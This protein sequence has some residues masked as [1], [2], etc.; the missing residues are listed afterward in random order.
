MTVSSSNRKAGPFLGNGVTTAFPFAFKVFKKED[1][2]VTFT[3]TNGADAPLV[4]DSDYSVALNSNQD[5]NPGGTITCPTVASALPPLATG[6]R[7]TLTG[8]LAYNQPTDIPNNSPFFAQTV[9]DAL[10]RAEIQIQQLKEITD[11]S[12][13]I[14]VSDAPL[15]PLPTAAVRSNTVVGFDALGNVITLPLPASIGAGDMRVDTFTAGVD[16]TAGVTTVLNLSR[17]PGN[18][19]NLEIFFDPLFQGPDQWNL[20]GSTVTFTGPIPVGVAK[21]FAR[22]GTTLSTQIPPNGSVGDAQLAWGS[23]LYRGVDTLAQMRT[24]N[25]ALYPCVFASGA[26]AAGD[27]GGG[28]YRVIAATQGAYVD[29]GG[30][31]IVG[32][33]GYVLQLVSKAAP[34]INQFGSNPTVGDNTAALNHALS[35]DPSNN[36]VRIPPGIVPFS[37]TL[38]VTTPGHYAGEG[39]YSALKPG[40]G[41]SGGSNNLQFKPNAALGVYLPV[42]EKFTLGDPNTGTRNGLNGIYI[43]TNTISSFVPKFTLRDASILAGV[44]GAAV[45][46]INT[47]ASNVNGGL[48][49]ANFD[50][51]ILQ[52][53]I[54]LNSTGDSNCI[55]KC[56]ISGPNT[57]IYAS[58]VSGASLLSIV[59]NNITNTN[60][61]IQI[62]AGARF[63]ILRNN[64][65]QQV[66][67]ANGAVHM[68][69]ISGANGTMV[70][71]E[72]RGNHFGLF[73]GVLNAANLRLAN[74]Q[75]TLVSEN[76]F[77]NANASPVAIIVDATC[78]NTRIGP[79]SYGTGLTTK[80]ID[81]G[82]GTM[83]V[84]KNATLA[85]AWLNY[86][87]NIAQFY[88]D[89]LGKVT[90][91][92]AVTG[93]SGTIC[94]LPVGFRPAQLSYFSVYSSNGG[95]QV[96][97]S[98]FVDTL[99]NV[100]YQAG[101]NVLFSLD[102][103]SFLAAGLADTPSDL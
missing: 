30:S 37:T 11:R 26:L 74:A 3:N 78:V 7:L 89:I 22:I 76:T 55:H 29:N 77:L 62:D 17:P 92:G 95:A 56:L 36:A 28:A 10:D 88:K 18:P 73:S 50:N 15:T 52:G 53:G 82:I 5:T 40:A 72:I 71:G 19:A 13:K 33:D 85:G 4:L 21:V 79:N 80:V 83:G 27:G 46:A 49:S 59:D 39:F 44:A 102:G 31:I 57:G 48:Y 98:V 47:P 45:L 90:L 86:S 34:T 51:N 66:P 64:L 93:G 25:H 75:G 20:S 69:N 103:V 12:I 38:L 23:I 2:L 70:N 6:T 61:Q 68:V 96:M 100:V 87:G 41:F 63:K 35:A 67:F 42:F 99:G 43:D 58:N 101:S 9:E 16:F 81:N 65:E 1:V 60:G 84:V 32:A 14:S 24:L 91:A 94:V 97:A 8:D 54:S